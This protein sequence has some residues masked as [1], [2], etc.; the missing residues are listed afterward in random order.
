MA[1]RQRGGG[2]RRCGGRGAGSLGR[3]GPEQRRNRRG[4]SLS[5][6]RHRIDRGPGAARCQGARGRTGQT[7][8]GGAGGGVR[9]PCDSRTRA[10]VR[11]STA[12]RWL[13]CAPR[14][15]SSAAAGRC[16]RAP[17][18][19]S[20]RRNCS[21][22]PKRLENLD[23]YLARETYLEALAAAMYAG[24]LGEPGALANVAEAA[25]AAVGR[26][27]KL[28]RPIDLLLSGMAN[29]SPVA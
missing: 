24:R 4:G 15:S 7:G 6:A 21:T 8:R 23:D 12:P 28:H 10:T 3:P 27:P 25:R 18:R 11:P 17:A 20:P 14:W 1:R 16:R 13:G 29:G 19:P 22:P 26:V 5:R 2:T 9:T